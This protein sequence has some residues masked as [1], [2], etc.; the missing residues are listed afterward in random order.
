MTEG[1]VWINPIPDTP[2]FS[3]LSNVPVSLK[4]GDDATSC[5]LGYAYSSG[6]FPASDERLL[7]NQTKHQSMVSDKFPSGHLCTS[8]SELSLYTCLKKFLPFIFKGNQNLL[9]TA[10]DVV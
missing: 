2:S 10:V 7:G 9:T 4:V 8:L 5:L 6:Y 3:A 1:Q